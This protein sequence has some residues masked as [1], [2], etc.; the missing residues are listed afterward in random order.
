[1]KPL[2]EIRQEIT[3]IF[4]AAR[5]PLNKPFQKAKYLKRA[6]FLSACETYLQTG[7]T[8]EFITSEYKRITR[9]ITVIATRFDA[10]RKQ[11]FMPDKTEKQVRSFY[12]KENQVP[13]LKKQLKTLIYLK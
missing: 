8:N 3:D 10:W 1:M 2:T 7:A 13:K 9:L 4:I 5:H 6:K 12:N 11:A